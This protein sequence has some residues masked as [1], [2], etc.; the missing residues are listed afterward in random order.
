[1]RGHQTSC[2]STQPDFL[3]F[4]ARAGL[5]EL[6][7][8]LKNDRY[9]P[10][11]MFLLIFITTFRASFCIPLSLPLANA[12]DRPAPL[13]L[14]STLIILSGYTFGTLHGAVISYLAAL[15][16]AVVV[17]LLSRHLF[18][19]SITRWLTSIKS[20]KRVVRAIERRPQLL[21]LIRL[22]PYPYNVMNCLLAASPTLTFR[23]Y[24]LCTALS[25]VKVAVHTSV[26]ASVRS[27]AQ[28]HAHA[29]APADE[30]QN[31]LGMYW[32]VAGVALCIGIVLYLAVVARRAVDEELGDDDAELPTHTPEERVSFLAASPDDDAEDDG[33]LA[34]MTERARTPVFTADPSRLV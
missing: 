21:F 2:I 25:L 30:Q 20:I 6:S 32:T 17:F 34:P 4:S 8:W 33:A 29:S 5:D 9:G 31:P 22:A 13:P 15:S 7:S 1:V 18:K 11:A 3:S 23:T 26:G 28:Y 27:F 10:A 19:D 12:C 24:F 14:Y 16:G